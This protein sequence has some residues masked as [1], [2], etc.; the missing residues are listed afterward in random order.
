MRKLSSNNAN[1]K[2]ST[3]SKSCVMI[4][5]KGSKRYKKT[6][7]HSTR[8]NTPVFRSAPSNHTFNTYCMECEEESNSDESEITVLSTELKIKEKEDD[9]PPIQ[10]HNAGNLVELT[11]DSNETISASTDEGEL[12][13]WHYRLGHLPFFKL[14]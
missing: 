11:N 4:L 5:Q 12:L 2:E 6:V 3:D 14:K 7:Y 13:R 1:F 10:N 8:T 9:L